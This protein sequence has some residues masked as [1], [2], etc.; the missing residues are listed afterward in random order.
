MAKPIAATPVIKGKD[1]DRIAREI[2]SGTPNTPARERTI[3][4]ADLVYAL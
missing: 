4:E 2:K 3:R 1:A